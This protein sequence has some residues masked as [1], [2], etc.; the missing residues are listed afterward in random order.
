MPFFRLTRTPLA[1]FFCLSHLNTRVTTQ[2]VWLPSIASTM[3]GSTLQLIRTLPQLSILAYTRNIKTEAP[4]LQK[5]NTCH[6]S[7]YVVPNGRNTLCQCPPTVQPAR[8]CGLSDQQ[9]GTSSQLTPQYRTTGLYGRRRP[10]R[11]A[12]FTHIPAVNSEAICQIPFSSG[13]V[14]TPSVK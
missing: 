14:P 9:R 7:I 2:H 13:N 12:V 5:W 10:P 6:T 11:F 4:L 1:R 8:Q 3:P